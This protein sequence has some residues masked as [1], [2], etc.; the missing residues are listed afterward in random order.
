[1]VCQAGVLAPAGTATYEAENWFE[2]AKAGMFAL[3]ANEDDEDRP[4]TL[5][6]STE[7][8]LLQ[9]R[10]VEMAIKFA[11]GKYWVTIGDE[12]QDT[13]KM[14]RKKFVV[15][16]DEFDSLRAL[17]AHYS[18]V[19]LPSHGTKLRTAVVFEPTEAEY[20][21]RRQASGAEDAKRLDVSK[22]KSKAAYA[23]QR[24]VSF[25][26]T[27]LYATGTRCDPHRRRALKT[28]RWARS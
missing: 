8:R 24:Q 5:L 15:V 13:K 17:V 21:E 23:K 3:L 18:N 26:P 22:A 14:I 2:Y 10:V 7:R 11:G 12:E 6:V 25:W 9:G 4:Y 19:N 20:A 27:K 1:M 16:G 28:T